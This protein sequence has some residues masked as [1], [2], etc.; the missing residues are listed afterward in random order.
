MIFL[1]DCNILKQQQ[2]PHIFT[3]QK[4]IIHILFYAKLK[5]KTAIP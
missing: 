4:K 2:Q 1:K 5:Y 3:K